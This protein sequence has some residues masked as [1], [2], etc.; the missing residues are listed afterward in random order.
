[1]NDKIKTY[2]PVLTI[3]GSDSGGGAGIQA[4]LKTFSALGCFG[5]SVI[6]ATTAQNTQGVRSIHDIPEQH[7]QDQLE[8]V[9]SDIG[10]K[11]IKIGMI[12]RPEVVRVIVEAL[13]RYPDIPVVFDPVMVATSGDRLIKEETVEVIKQELFP[14]SNVITPNMDEA[15]VLIGKAVNDPQEMEKAAQ[16]LLGYGSGFVLVKGGHLQGDQVSDVL[17]GDG[18]TH[19]FES[20]KIKTKN[21]HGTGCT[22]SSAIAVFLAEGQEVRQAVAS[23]RN[24]VFQAIDAGKAVKTGQ[25]S[26]PLNHFY[27]PKKMIIHELDQ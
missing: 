21:V 12:N 9:L 15:A 27:Y 2:L 1:M 7:I 26:G 19:V 11:A 23:A 16:T 22:L 10:P 8:A 18:Q 25:G 5:T 13:R 17:C 20:A 3:A 24:Y 4:D 14:V 6:T